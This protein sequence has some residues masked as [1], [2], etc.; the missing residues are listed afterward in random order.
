MHPELNSAVTCDIRCANPKPNARLAR[1]KSNTKKRPHFIHQSATSVKYPALGRQDDIAPIAIN[2]SI[3]LVINQLHLRS[4][5]STLV[6]AIHVYHMGHLGPQ[7]KI[8]LNI[9]F[10]TAIATYKK[11]HHIAVKI[12]K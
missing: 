4:W 2:V 5:T 9:N 7:C 8:K 10:L 1:P 12:L 3:H 6:N 11:Y